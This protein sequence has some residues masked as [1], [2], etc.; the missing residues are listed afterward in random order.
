[1]AGNACTIVITLK[2]P[3]DDCA[4]KKTDKRNFQDTIARDFATFFIIQY[5]ATTGS[6]LTQCRDNLVIKS[7]LLYD[8]RKI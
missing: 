3:I 7:N 5:A 1:M 8:V 4:S 6:T 2:I